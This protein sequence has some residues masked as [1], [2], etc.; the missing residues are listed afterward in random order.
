MV[1]VLKAGAVAL[2]TVRYSYVLGC[3]AV[4]NIAALA[5]SLALEYQISHGD[6]YGASPRDDV[7]FIRARGDLNCDGKY[8]LFEAMLKLK[9]GKVST[10][11]GVYSQST[12]E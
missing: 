5:K 10:G 1:P 6:A 7:L 9:A 2:T 3:C 11:S 12:L 4:A 8:S